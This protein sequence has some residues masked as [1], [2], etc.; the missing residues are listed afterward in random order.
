VD[1]YF[2]RHADAIPL[3]EG[4][5]NNDEDRPLTDEG[6]AQSRALAAGLKRLD[7]RLGTVL[8]SPLVRARQTAEDLVKEWGSAAPDIRVCDQLAPGAKAKRLARFLRELDGQ[9]LALVGHMPDLAEHAAW[10]IGSKKAQVDFAK[11]GVAFIRCSDEPRKSS[12]MLI[13]LATPEWM[14]S[15]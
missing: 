2:I 14:P 7:V 6:R 5:I 9:S 11:G 8:T 3:G 13:W 12:G 15:V 1:L 10:F 4:G